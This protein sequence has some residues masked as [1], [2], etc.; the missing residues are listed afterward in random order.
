[1]YD[2]ER[3]RERESERASEQASER[4]EARVA[5]ERKRRLRK[6]VYARIFTT[7]VYYSSFLLLFTTGTLPFS[8]SDAWASATPMRRFRLVFGIIPTRK[9]AL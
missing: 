3:E 7:T 2:D 9:K 8:A 6:S 4:E 5:S 1:M